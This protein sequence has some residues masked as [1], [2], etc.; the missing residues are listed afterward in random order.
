MENIEFI[1]HLKSF[2]LSNYFFMSDVL[3]SNNDNG[4]SGFANFF[5][6]YYKSVYPSAFINSWTQDMIHTEKIF[7]STKIPNYLSFFKNVILCFGCAPTYIQKFIVE[8]ILISSVIIF[9][10]ST[11]DYFNY[12]PIVFFISYSTAAF[13]SIVFSIHTNRKITPSSSPSQRV[14]EVRSVSNHHNTV[15]LLNIEEEKFKSSDREIFINQTTEPLKTGEIVDVHEHD[16]NELIST[17]NDHITSNLMNVETNVKE[18]FS[19]SDQVIVK[20]HTT[21]ETKVGIIVDLHE[22]GL[23]DVYYIDSE[24]I[25]SNV[26]GSHISFQTSCEETVRKSSEEEKQDCVELNNIDRVQQ[27]NVSNPTV[28]MSSHITSDIIAEDNDINEK[29]S[30]FENNSEHVS[31]Y[32]DSNYNSDDESNQE[33]EYDSDYS[34]DKEIDYSEYDG[35]ES[36]SESESSSGSSSS[37]S[38][39]HDGG[40][41]SGRSGSGSS[42]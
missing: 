6:K 30:S 29:N 20:N 40:S 11:Q 1:N 19:F 21:G 28:N 18:K 7:S 10:Y 33:S 17:S 15:S 35:S 42:V 25:G 27:E 2:S 16:S 3:V 41:E 9:F 4:V 12:V 22:H 31:Q 34:S 13:G 39:N 36:W 23:Y 26:D 38:Y 37:S 32:E 5:I 14:D 24:Q 8:L